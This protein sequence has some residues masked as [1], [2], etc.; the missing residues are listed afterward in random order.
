VDQ[1][2]TNSSPEEEKN[3]HK[4]GKQTTQTTRTRPELQG[5]AQDTNNRQY[6]KLTPLRGEG[7]VMHRNPKKPPHH[8]RNPKTTP[9]RPQS[10]QKGYSCNTKMGT[11]AY[12]KTAIICYHS[13]GQNW[14][15]RKDLNP[16]HLGF[17]SKNSSSPRGSV[18]NF[19]LS[20]AQR[21]AR[22]DHGP[23]ANTATTQHLNKYCLPR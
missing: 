20:G 10:C 17:R 3:P 15:G 21:H 9:I 12:P 7:G 19:M 14:W 11:N 1:K 6:N 8:E 18:P 13:H 16:R 5:D 23:P 2:R 22:L 4:T